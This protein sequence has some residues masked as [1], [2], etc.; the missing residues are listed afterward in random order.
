MCLAPHLRARA[1]ANEDLPTPPLPYTT[2]QGTQGV[3]SW[4]AEWRTY[5][6]AG[7]RAT[8]V[9]PRRTTLRASPM[10]SRRALGDRV[11]DSRAGPATLQ[12]LVPWTH[13]DPITPPSLLDAGWGGR[14]RTGLVRRLPGG[15]DSAGQH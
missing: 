7:R 4:R 6:D 15:P 13:P 1:E 10:R 5:N 2:T 9:A 14:L 8:S 12:V 3:L 11:R